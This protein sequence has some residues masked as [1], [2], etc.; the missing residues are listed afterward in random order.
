MIPTTAPTVTHAET[1]WL[2]TAAPLFLT[3]GVIL[4]FALLL[5][6]RLRAA[7][8]ALLM[9][10]AAGRQRTAIDQALI[11]AP[12]IAGETQLLGVCLL[13]TCAII[14]GLSRLAPLFV[15]VV[16][17]GPAAALLI[18][19]ALWA[20]ERRYVARL[21]SALPAAVG[22][23]E[24]QLRGGSGLQT[25]LQKVLADMPAGPLRDEWLFLVMKLG[26]PLGTSTLA[27]P[28]HVVAALLAQTPSQRHAAL[29]GHLEVALEQ[30]HSAMVQRVRAA[31]VALQAAEQRRSTALTELAQMRYSGIAIS[32]A[33]LTMALYLFATQ[34][35][36]FA[37]AY[38]G[39]IGALV[40]AVVVTALLAPLVGGF[41]LSQAGDLD[42]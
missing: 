6:G 30:P 34:Q 22:R 26:T 38:Q 31:Y 10:R 18:W 13:A 37:V 23:L 15:A 3:V 33:G 29:L 11:W 8:A 32:L 5:R 14:L 40:G 36:R 19:M 25:A 39:V 24:A 17:A 9:R 41:F 4:L 7:L 21:D 35:Q 16:L 28:Q 2:V 12:Q 42:Y 20:L 27:T 1:A